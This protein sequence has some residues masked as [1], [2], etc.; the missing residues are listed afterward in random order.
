MKKLLFFLFLSG[1]GFND[2]H[3]QEGS[4]GDSASLGILAGRVR[5]YFNREYKDSLY[6]LMGKAFREKIDDRQFKQI[7]HSLRSQLGYWQ[8]N[9]PLAFQSGIASYQALF[10]NGEILFRLSTDTEGKIETF[11]FSPPD[12]S[13]S[14]KRKTTPPRTDNTMKTALDTMVAMA[15]S[16]YVTRENAHA[17][18]IALISANGVRYYNY[19]DIKNGGAIPDSLTLYEIGSVTKTF[20]ATLLAD[21]VLN[22]G[23]DLKDPIN[24]YLP[25]DIPKLAFA[26]LPITLES[27]SNHSSGLPRLPLNLQVSA[28]AANPYAAY[29]NENLYAFLKTFRPTRPPGT[30]YEYS[31]LAVGLL[32]TLLSSYTGKPFDQL[33]KQTICLPLGMTNT[34][35]ALTPAQQ[36]LL[37]QGY[38]ESGTP[39]GTWE[40]QS[41][42]GAGALRSDA[43][44]MARYVQAQLGLRPSKLDKAIAMTHNPSFVYGQQVVG[45]GWLLGKKT[46]DQ[47]IVFHAGQTGGYAS[48]VAF[49]K[50]SKKGI[51]VLTN[52]SMAIGDWP[53][54]L[55]ETLPSDL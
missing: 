32:G 55:L 35:Q 21:N 44:D 41:L 49:D 18:S 14:Y 23:M 33:V 4:K 45:L 51:V 10:A 54:K 17:L 15:V 11:L 1:L 40:F 53:M 31:N 6:S 8:G 43:R 3:A 19:G 16:E 13:K 42:A 50:V 28:N 36:Q 25:T 22:N 12:P 2:L 48:F 37:A 20:T 9:H 24:K 39:Q 5:E 47:D 27:L 52:T 38:L 46:A 29:S 34:A 7:F 30:S 26:D